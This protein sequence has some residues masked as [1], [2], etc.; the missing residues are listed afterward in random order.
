MRMLF[1]ILSVFYLISVPILAS[2]TSN[3]CME[4]WLARP[5]VKNQL[6]AY[7]TRESTNYPSICF[8]VFYFQPYSDDDPNADFWFVEKNGKQTVITGYIKT[9]ADTCHC[10]SKIQS[11]M[12]IV[13]CYRG[14]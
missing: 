2:A 5:E 8:A 12:Y 13:Q 14:A 10:S 1:R 11:N 6:V 9:E 4:N 7:W 3:Q